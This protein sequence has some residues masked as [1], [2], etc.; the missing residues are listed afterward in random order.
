M[1]LRISVSGGANYITKKVRVI[2]IT[3]DMPADPP[4]YPSQMISN[5]LKQN[6]S[7]SLYKILSS[8]EILK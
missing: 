4:L 5:Y 3:R 1:C 7:Y 8:G 6:G 2:T